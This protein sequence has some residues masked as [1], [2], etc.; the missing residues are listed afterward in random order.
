[1]STSSLQKQ[2]QRWMLS[3]SLHTICFI[4][5]L[6]ALKLEEKSGSLFIKSNLKPSSL[7]KLPI[8]ILQTLKFEENDELLDTIKVE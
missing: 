3:H 1:M 2:L 6:Q 4:I 7:L 8:I 5:T